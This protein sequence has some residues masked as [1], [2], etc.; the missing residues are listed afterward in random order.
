MTLS[1]YLHYSIELL[2]DVIFW[3]EKSISVLQP[4][5]YFLSCLWTF[6]PV[7]SG[8]G[9]SQ[10]RISLSNQGGPIKGS[11]GKIALKINKVLS[12]M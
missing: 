7:E 4:E 9:D 10:I 11:Q 8:T 12:I 1:S 3:S 5:N 2:N 6:V